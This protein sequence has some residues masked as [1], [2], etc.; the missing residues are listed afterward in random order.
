MPVCWIVDPESD[1]A[2]IVTP[3]HMT[4]V[5]DG[6]LRAGG[7]EMPLAEVLEVRRLE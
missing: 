2:R 5:T 1:E 3:G 6:I 7:I 4:K